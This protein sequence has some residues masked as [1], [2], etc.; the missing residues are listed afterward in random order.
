MFVFLLQGDMHRRSEALTVSLRFNFTLSKRP[1]RHSSRPD[2]RHPSGDA[3][4]RCTCY[5]SSRDRHPQTVDNRFAMPNSSSIGAPL[6]FSALFRVRAR[7]LSNR[8]PQ[9][10]RTGAV[11]SGHHAR[12]CS[13]ARS[14]L[15]CCREPPGM[16]RRATSNI[17]ETFMVVFLL[18]GMTRPGTRPALR[19]RGFVGHFSAVSVKLAGEDERAR[20]PVRRR[21]EFVHRIENR[22][23]IFPD[24]A[25]SSRIRFFLPDMCLRTHKTLR[26]MISSFASGS[27]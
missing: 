27:S 16:S 21:R 12:R 9:S 6:T 26:A 13:P 8:L 10:G 3:R 2:D 23:G 24:S 11:I 20:S 22:R 14:F 19:K 25:C 4:S 1:C 18:C 7:F 15:R 5:T 17:S